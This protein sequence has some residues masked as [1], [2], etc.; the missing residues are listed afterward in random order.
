MSDRAHYLMDQIEKEA[1][2]L[3][4]AKLQLDCDWR[5]DIESDSHVYE[6]WD[7]IDNIQAMKIEWNNL[8][9]SNEAYEENKS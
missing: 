4:K 2:V 3:L 8:T 9:D 1:I 6:L 5:N 7:A